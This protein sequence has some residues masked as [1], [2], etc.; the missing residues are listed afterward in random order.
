M[1]T[2]LSLAAGLTL[3]LIALS[4]WH[5]IDM[6][7]RGYCFEQQRVLAAEEIERA[8]IL[9]ELK[10]FPPSVPVKT[11]WL[12]EG[13]SVQTWAVPRSAEPFSGVDDYLSRNPGGVQIVQG[14]A[15]ARAA[16]L[17]SR[18]IGDEFYIVSLRYPVRFS[19]DGK[20][21]TIPHEGFVIVSRCGKVV[22]VNADDRFANRGV[23]VC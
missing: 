20:A 7:G 14:G 15:H 8:A 3:L 4:G 2:I 5:R 1:K 22:A 6:A 13:R 21:R 10:K 9:H 11:E 23:W 17:L 12:G 19:E 18:L 16:G